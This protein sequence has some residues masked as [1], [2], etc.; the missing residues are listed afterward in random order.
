[1][2]LRILVGNDN[3]QNV[4]N[5]NELTDN[6]VEVK[7]VFDKGDLKAG[8]VVGFY[9]GENIENSK[10]ITIT[11]A[12]IDRGNF[13][14]LT[15]VGN[16]TQIGFAVITDS[17]DISATGYTIDKSNLKD[18]SVEIVED[19][20]KDGTISL[21]EL[22][23]QIDVK[24]NLPQDAQLGDVV[25]VGVP[26]SGE[27]KFTLT[28]ENLNAGSLNVAFDN[29]GTG[30]I[31]VLAGIKDEAGN[32]GSAMAKANIQIAPESSNDN[33]STNEDTAYTLKLSDFGTFGENLSNDIADVSFKINSLP[34]NGVI[35]FDGVAISGATEFSAQDVK[36]GKVVYE[37]AN[38]SDVSSDVSFTVI[39]N[40]GESE[41]YNLSINVN[42]IADAPVISIENPTANTQLND[43][44]AGEGL[45]FTSY[46]CVLYR[47]LHPFD[48]VNNS[49]VLEAFADHFADP[50]Y[51]YETTI[52][53]ALEANNNLLSQTMDAAK[54]F[55]YLEAG[56]KVVFNGS[57]DDSALIK[58]GGEVILYTQG[59][60]HGA[61]S[62]QNKGVDQVG[63]GI[64]HSYGTFEVKQSGYYELET[65]VMNVSRKGAYEI[66]MSVDGGANY[67]EINTK[68]FDIYSSKDKIAEYAQ[69]TGEA[70]QD[71][72]ISDIS[73]NYSDN[74]GSERHTNYISGLP[75]GTVLKDG[76]HEITIAQDNQK[77]NVNGFDLNNLSVKIAT[78]GVYD[79][80]ITGEAVEHANNNTATSEKTIK[81]SV[82]NFPLSDEA[83][84]IPE[85]CGCERDLQ[86]HIGKSYGNASDSNDYLVVGDD[87]GS[88]HSYIAQN[89]HVDMGA[90]NDVIEL[91]G[92]IDWFARVDMGEGNDVIR[93]GAGSIK[94]DSIV[95]MGAGDDIITTR[96]GIYDRAI[97]HMGE[98]N[99]TLHVNCNIDYD[100]KVYTEEGNDTVTLGGGMY[101]HALLNTGDGNDFVSMNASMNH[102]SK[103]LTGNGNDIV[104]IG[105]HVRHNSTIDTGA[106]DD[107]VSIKHHLGNH[108]N[109]TTGE[110]DDTLLIGGSIFDN[111]K[112]YMG[113]GND[114]MKVD[115]NIFHKATIDLGAGDDNFVFG[116]HAHYKSTVDLGSG[117]DTLTLTN[118]DNRI[119]L[120][121]IADHFKNVEVLDISEGHGNTHLK[122]NVNDIISMTDENNTLKIIG[123]GDSISNDTAFS[124]KTFGQAN[125]D[126]WASLGKDADGF[127][128]FQGTDS[129]GRTATLLVDQNHIHTDF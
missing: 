95:D 71:I 41:A 4:I 13:S 23:G 10:D 82:T 55:I 126:S 64:T 104:N 16:S 103:L 112:V 80:K 9:S 65:Y 70:N 76:V 42:A 88:S 67:Q 6:K 8:Q 27:Q 97:V 120:T 62:T 125:V 108:A 94:G 87:I 11:Q 98:G 117:V 19:T 5:A 30:S 122:F 31:T 121:N 12:D 38:N 128:I 100:A 51:K 113:D 90:G 33:I 7:V 35:K 119:D 39:E 29:P 2:A 21:K 83:K 56:Q 124:W 118:P 93:S 24:V 77:I 123:D 78:A 47:E 25:T 116:G 14:V 57:I 114:T 109:V 46:D 72:K 66:K 81:V 92:A 36:D 60:A 107:F 84:F 43:V 61:F 127:T 74:D 101:A 86:Y 37:P 102:E 18:I 91:D 105:D 48:F 49:N 96:G 68:N 15:D 1:M 45:S 59:D 69:N 75:A 44:K 106:G 52:K 50:R 111:A 73:V 3:N 99:D 28:Q 58:L 115:G 85:R 63:G 32:T 34:T 40:G 129:A 26:G 89:V 54:G 110:G 22:N 53:D 79:L 20:N 17:V